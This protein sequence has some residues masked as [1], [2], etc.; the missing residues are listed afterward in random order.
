M[1]RKIIEGEWT[2]Y[3]PSQQRIQHREIISHREA[4][5][6][7]HL[8]VI[9]F[10]DG[11]SLLISIRETRPHERVQVI[12]SHTKLI[13]EAAAKKTARVFVKDLKP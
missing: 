1:A 12:Q 13:R 8:K 7:E 6:L 5:N 2:G 9:V 3:T 11:T 10:T 4:Q